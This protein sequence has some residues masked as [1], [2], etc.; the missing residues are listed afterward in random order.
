MGQWPISTRGQP[1]QDQLADLEALE[2]F[3]IMP[4]GLKKPSYL[5]FLAMNQMDFQSAGGILTLF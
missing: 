3:N 4:E 2:F 5:P 1:T